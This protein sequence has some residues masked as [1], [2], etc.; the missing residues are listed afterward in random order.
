MFRIGDIPMAS[1]AGLAPMAGV[2]D[3]V[4][5][6]LCHRQG[7]AWAVS[8]MLS[9][10]GW[11]FSGGR[12]INAQ[13]ILRRLPGE[14]IA[15][16]QLFGSEPEYIAEAGR[17]LEDAGFQF[18]DLNF[19]C[20]APKITANG[21]GSA[22][23]REPERIGRVVRA[24]REAVRLPVTVKIRSGWDADSVNAPEVARICEDN[25]ADAVA[26]HTRTRAQQYSGEADWSVI[27][28]VKE[29]VTIPVL[30]NGDIREGKDALRMLEQTGCDGVIVGRAAQGNPW[31]FREIAA[32]LMGHTCP[33]PTNRERVDTALEHYRLEID[34]FGE[35]R[36]LLEMRKHIAW[37]VHGM[38]GASR[39]RERINTMNHSRDVMEALAEFARAQEE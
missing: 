22:M 32:A 14:G 33:P 5:R 21:E 1:G 26:V 13:D 37:Y 15:G 19:G 8:E 24:L 7:A 25:G 16:L 11:V 29:A 10:K 2:T 12:N 35:R 4:M 3:A 30:G 39:F 23:M 34:L 18:I 17:Q 38:H 6:L 28:R 36:A 20:P 9:A 27:R 31:V